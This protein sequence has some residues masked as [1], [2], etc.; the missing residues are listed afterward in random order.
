MGRAREQRRS[1]ICWL[2]FGA[3]L[4]GTFPVLAQETCLKQVFERY[5]LGSDV[6]LLLRKG[7][8]PQYKHAEGERLAYIFR[9][10]PERIYVLAFRSRIYKVL[11]RYRGATQLRYEDLYALLRSKYGLGEDRSKFP[12]Y[13]TTASR[14]L[15]SIRRGEGRAVH[16]WQPAEDW[17]VELSWTREM[18]LS[19]AYV[20]TEL[21]DEQ[22]AAAEQ[23]L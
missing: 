6:S 7:P 11:R 19:L 3:L 23:R 16:Y 12:P 10:G 20:G 4:A 8:Q 14:R 2:V 9:E 22:K 13:A 21:N 15:G 5:C 17:H 18:G 1:W